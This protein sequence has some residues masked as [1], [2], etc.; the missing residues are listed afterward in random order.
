MRLVVLAFVMGCGPKP[1]PDVEV[2][3]VTMDEA[4]AVSAELTKIG[5]PCDR[6]KMRELVDEEAL[7][8]RYRKQTTDIATTTASW[9]MASDHIGATVLCDW[10]ANAIE[11]KLLRVRQ[12]DGQPRPLFR[13]IIKQPR[14]GMTAV[15]YED[16][17]LGKSKLDHKVRVIDVY[18]YVQGGW[19]TERLRGFTDAVIDS[20]SDDPYDTKG[21]STVV[22]RVGE[23]QKQ[24]RP[25]EAFDLI[26][27][28]PTAVRKSRTMQMMRVALASAISDDM[29]R[30]VLDEV[31]AAFPNDPSIALLQID[32]AFLRRDFDA[33]LRYIDQ[34][35]TA[36]GGD[37]WQ[38]ALRAEALSQRN[39]PGD[40]AAAARAAN[41]A[42]TTEPTL[43]KGWWAVLDV[44]LVQRDWTTSLATM[45]EIQRRFGVTFNDAGLR[46]TAVYAGLLE[47]KQYAAW[48]K[49]H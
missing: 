9:Q 13:R 8:S 37:A 47:T 16:L 44:A 38:D 1:M 4:K 7:L 24:G 39:K 25:Q 15:A 23:L 30:K 42:T 35:D 28:L 3:P 27:T 41:R 31:G 43:A 22:Q 18:S 36:I 20:S 19:L 48:R 14:D 10:Q 29:Y 12:V 17:M 49:A 2:D 33:G 32:A 6:T 11:Y 21:P 5:L 45:D 34:V 26:A 46:A 40:L